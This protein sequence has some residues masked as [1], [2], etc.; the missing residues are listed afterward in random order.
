MA[1]MQACGQDDPTFFA[2]PG[3]RAIVNEDGSKTVLDMYDPR[4]KWCWDKVSVKGL[5]PYEYRALLDR[6]GGAS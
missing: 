6:L 5:A 3:R 1:R 4:N 2:M